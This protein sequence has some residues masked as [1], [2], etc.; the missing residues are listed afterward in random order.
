MT[1]IGY[2]LPMTRP[3]KLVLLAYQGC[4]LL[5]V[6]GPAAVFG[7]AN[8]ARGQPFYDLRIVSPDGGAVESNSGVEIQS[9]KIGGQPE[10]LLVAGGSRGLKAAME[11]AD[12][13][14]M[15]A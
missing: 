15:L 3:H 13:P 9:C 7:A 12:L 6:T 14:Q 1:N 11:R 10:T 8:D 5:D 2:F 4:Q